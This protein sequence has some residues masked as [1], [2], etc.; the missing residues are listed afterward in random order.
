MSVYGS[1]PPI[2]TPRQREIYEFVNDNIVNRGYEPTVGEIGREFGIKSPNDVMCHL[3][4]LEKKGLIL[5]EASK[6]KSRSVIEAR[7]IRVV[8]QASAKRKTTVG[9][10]ATHR[11][12]Q[13]GFAFRDLE[14]FQQESQLPI[15]AIQ[16]VL[17]LP[18]RTFQ[19]RKSEGRLKAVES[20]RLWR[21]VRLFGLAKELFEGDTTAASEWFQ[22]P[23]EGLGRRTPLEMSETEAG[24]REVE[25]L[26]GRLEHGVFS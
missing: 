10:L 12:I 9:V 15:D 19:R 1:K 23:V 21:L 13:T 5:R 8:S 20:D 7:K 2:L 3:K 14:A 24:A 26:I 22:N 16:R 11:N 25:N 18:P 6:P 17:S 4:A